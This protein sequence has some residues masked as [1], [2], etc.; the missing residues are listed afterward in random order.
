MTCCSVYQVEY[1]VDTPIHDKQFMVIALD[2]IQSS[3]TTSKI[4]SSREQGLGETRT[5]FVS[6]R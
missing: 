4:V 3:L 6:Q 2:W 5:T 1:L